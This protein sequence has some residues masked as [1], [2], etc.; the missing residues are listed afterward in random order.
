MNSSHTYLFHKELCMVFFIGNQHNAAI[1]QHIAQRKH[2]FLEKTK[3]N[4]IPQ[5]KT[6]QN[7][8]IWNYCI[9]A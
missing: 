6:P 8:F 9:R 2:T 3:E 1:L 7:Q 4:S 5:N